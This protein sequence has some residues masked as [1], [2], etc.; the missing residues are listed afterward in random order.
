MDRSSV[1]WH[2]PMPAVVTPFAADGRIDE[3]GFATNL[4]GLME[5]GATGFIVGGCTGEFWAMTR[6]ERA[7]IFGIAAR[8]AGGRATVIAGASAHT[9][10]EAIWLAR[11]AQDAGCDGAMVLPPYFV[12]V[13]EDE[14]VRHYER[15]AEGIAF[16]VMLYNIPQFAVNA[17]GPE[18]ALRLADID[19]VVAI[20]ESCG[21]WVNLHRT[22]MAVRHRL[23]VF[24]GP[25]TLYGTAALAAGADGFI[26]CFPNVWRPGG[27]ELYHAARRGDLDRAQELQETGLKLTTLFT[28]GGCTLY[29]ATKAAMEMLGLPGGVPRPPLEPTGPA[30]REHLRAGLVAL[31]LLEAGRTDRQPERALG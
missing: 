19:T 30:A 24:C 20:K 3:A 21:D 2:G 26:D 4:E 18:L 29:S 6:E 5:A 28:T 8:T 11:A 9:A 22:L 14:I 31:G 27:L 23:R 16:P 10:A 17:I 12:P 25:S 13:T 1:D 7:Q 15:I